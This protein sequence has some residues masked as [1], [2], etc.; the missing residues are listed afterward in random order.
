MEVVDYV[1]TNSK[2]VESRKHNIL[3]PICLGNKFFSHKNEITDNVRKYIEWALKFTKEKVLI[4]VVDKIQD[5]NYYVRSSGSKS[6]SASSRRVL[7]DGQE[8]KNNI[9]STIKNSFS[10][11]EREKID[12]ICY[13]EY[14]K[15]DPNCI[16]VTEKVYAQFKDDASFRESV[17]GA[18]K[19]SVNDR[20][21][22]DEEYLTLC[23]YVLDEFALVY[24]GIEYGGRYYG[25]YV[26]PEIDAVVDLVASIQQGHSFIEL[27]KK[28]PARQI[29]LAIVSENKGVKNLVAQKF[30]DDFA[31]SYEDITSS[32]GYSL[33]DLTKSMY[34]KYGINDGAILDV[35]CGTGKLKLVLGNNYKYTGV[36]FSKNML[37]VAK[38]RG[39]QIIEGYLEDVV[40]VIGDKSYDHVLCLSVLYFVEDAEPIIKKLEK[41][42]R[43]SLIIGFEKY[44]QKQLNLVFNGYEGVKRYNHSSALVKNPT[45]ILRDRLFW[46]YASGE[47]IYGDFV[48]KKL[49]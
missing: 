44:T 8:I 7:R 21:F 17:L 47:T 30:F 28:L 48:F 19:S 18:V 27:H 20:E 3:I 23:E 35:G 41:I 33:F 24:T 10:D 40:N 45:E 36:D 34:E 16:E 43:K 31:N 25:L 15:T 37:S 13:E 32:L 9:L 39:Y 6:R 14:E 46:T 49:V 42:A 5:T 29:G 2:E 12:I 1:N 22:S 38:S 4:L 26:Y 11:T